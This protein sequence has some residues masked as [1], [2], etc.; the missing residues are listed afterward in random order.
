LI[1]YDY[2]D[3]ET[4]GILS[5]KKEFILALTAYAPN[6]FIF[7]IIPIGVSSLLLYYYGYKAHTSQ[8][9]AFVLGIIAAVV[10]VPQWAPQIY[11]TWKMKSRGSLSVVMLIIQFPGSLLV[12]YFQA[13]LFSTSISTWLPYFFSAIQ[14]GMLLALCLWFMFKDWR[15]GKHSDKEKQESQSLLGDHKNGELTNPGSDE[16]G[17][18]S[19]NIRINS[20]RRS[21]E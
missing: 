7:M 2:T 8:T 11:K 16:E 4:G 12:T 18:A 1:Y 19:P 5:Q 13:F 3:T 10:T 14:Q 17:V 9:W 6:L 20:F 21:D 15:A